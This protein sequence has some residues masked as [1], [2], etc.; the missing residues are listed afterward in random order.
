MFSPKR[1]VERPRSL[2]GLRKTAT[3]LSFPFLAENRMNS[4]RAPDGSMLMSLRY[5]S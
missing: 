2:A 3:S 4:L 1:N 5:I